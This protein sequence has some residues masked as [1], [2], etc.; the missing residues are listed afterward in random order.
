MQRFK[1]I[2]C[3]VN[4]ERN[5]TSALEHAAKLAANNQARLTVIEVI[6]EIPPDTKLFERVMSP[7]DLQEKIV[8]E[9]QSKL[10][11]IILP[12][13]KKIEVKY[14]VLTGIV[15]LEVIYEVLRSGHDLVF[16]LAESSGLLDRVFGSDDMH[17]LR[18]CPC[19]VWL[20]KSN[21]PKS[22]QKILAAVDADDTY[23]LE[24]RTTRHLLNIQIL[25]MASSL[26]LSESAELDIVHVWEAIGEGAMRFGFINKP[27]DEINVYVE[28]IRKKQNN[29]LNILMSEIT[30]KLGRDALT[31]ISPKMHSLKGHP[32]IGV[33]EFAVKINADLVVM[34]TVARTGLPGYFMGNTAESILNQ[35]SCSVLTI[36]PPE[37]I[38]PVI[39]DE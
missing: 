14:K 28:E 1:N 30:D 23:P 31:Y 7:V 26:A 27:E 10:E 11:Q 6:D 37:F 2:L 19:P 32:R 18:K 3:V 16:K 24:E 4:T 33:P 38:T 8:K 20:V 35:L 22:Y 39:L 21:S 25:E 9:C 36:K 17:L 12:W 5:D 15:F 29:N 34:G 13:S